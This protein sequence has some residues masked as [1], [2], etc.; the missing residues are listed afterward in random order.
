MPKNIVTI[1][2]LLVS[3]ATIIGT[4]IAVIALIPAFGQWLYPKQAPI[5]YVTLPPDNNSSSTSETVLATEN[6]EDS[7]IHTEEPNLIPTA[8]ETT[9]RI[10]DFSAC[11]RSCNGNNSAFTF[12][13]PIATIYIEWSYENIPHGASYVRKW[14]MNGRE[15]I[16]YDCIWTGNENGRDSVKL[17][18]PKGLHSGTWELTIIV[19]GEILLSEQISIS[20]NSDYWDPA[21]TLNSCYGTTD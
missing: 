9:A 16:K 17:T 3:L 5:Q 10:Y 19:N 7:N 4:C 20:G 2:G 1:L 6:S 13:S 18:E 8:I 11:Q 15:W 21:G 12:S 14:S